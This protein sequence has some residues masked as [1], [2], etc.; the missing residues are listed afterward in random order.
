MTKGSI[1]KGHWKKLI[2]I[3]YLI[4]HTFLV[5]LGVFFFFRVG[6]GGGGV[7]GV[8]GWEGQDSP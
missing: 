6:G 4:L 8:G 3:T 7:G 1:N 2:H 5:L